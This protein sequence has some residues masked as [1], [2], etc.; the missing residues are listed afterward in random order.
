MKYLERTWVRILIAI[1]SASLIYELITINSNDPNHLHSRDNSSLFILIVGPIIYL[2]LT[3]YVNRKSKPP[4]K[5]L[6]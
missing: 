6:K 1:L 2:L 4:F 3:R 5:N